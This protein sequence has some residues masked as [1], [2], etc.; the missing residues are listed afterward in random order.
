[1]ALFLL[2]L[3]I[4]DESKEDPISK[5]INNTFESNKEG[6]P[7]KMRREPDDKKAFASWNVDNIARVFKDIYSGLNWNTVFES[8]AKINREDLPVQFLDSG[9]EQ[10]QFAI[11]FQLIGKLKTGNS[12]F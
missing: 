7:D 2:Q 11:L 5:I 8:F 10:K 4:N 12:N 9:F 1:M 6:A 3:A